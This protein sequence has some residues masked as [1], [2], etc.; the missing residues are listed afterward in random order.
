MPGPG[1]L[2]PEKPGFN[3]EEKQCKE[4]LPDYQI[5]IKYP[6]YGFVSMAL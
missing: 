1:A 4:K 3:M 2:R 5:I 6:K